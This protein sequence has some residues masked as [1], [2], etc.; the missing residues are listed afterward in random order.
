[1]CLTNVSCMVH[2]DMIAKLDDDADAIGGQGRLDLETEAALLMK[3][4]ASKR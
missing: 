4:H 2:E 3:W 1:M